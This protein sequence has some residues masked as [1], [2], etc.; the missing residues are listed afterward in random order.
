MKNVMLKGGGRYNEVSPVIN[1]V[2][3]QAVT[4]IITAFSIVAG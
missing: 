4:N 2:G 1:R 3:K